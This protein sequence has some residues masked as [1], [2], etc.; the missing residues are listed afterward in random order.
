MNGSGPV[1]VDEQLAL[2]GEPTPLRI[3]VVEWES[4]LAN[5]SVQARYWAKVYRIDS[6]TDCWFFFGGISSTGHASFRAASRPGRTRR[7]TVPGHLYGYQLAHG[8]IPRLGW[9]NDNP[10]VCHTCDNHSCQQPAHLR[11][12]TAAENRAE[13][14]ARRHNPESSLADLR[15]PA[16]RSRAIGVAVRAG[17]ANH[18]SEREIA[19]RIRA[20]LAAGRPFSLW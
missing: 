20:V 8:V 15:G 12:G 3:P 5:E 6:S 17:R 10:T 4:W 16:G 13:W 19:D 18:D 1:H 11:L 14:L 9:G 7:G 2:I